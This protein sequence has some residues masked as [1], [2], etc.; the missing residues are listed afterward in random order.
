MT[1]RL[2]VNKKH[3]VSLWR[4]WAIFVILIFLKPE[5][6]ED[7]D[8]LDFLFNA[9]RFSL[10]IYY[11]FKLL[12]IRRN[13]N[14]QWLILVGIGAIVLFSTVVNG[15]LYSKALTHFFPSIGFIAFVSV[16]KK[17][18]KDI[19]AI[20][21]NMGIIL[22]VLNLVTVLLFPDGLLF[23]VADSLKIW[24][25]GQKQ[26]LGGFI[27]PFI[28]ATLVQSYYEESK[29]KNQIIVF[30]LSCITLTLEKSL[31]AIICVAVFAFLVIF[32]KYLLKVR[33]SMLVA[34]IAGAF[35]I[36]QYISFNFEEMVWLQNILSDIGQDGISKART[37]RV[38]FDMWKFA[39]DTIKSHLL[40]GVGNL[41]QDSWY[42]MSGLGYHSMLDNMYMDVLLTGGLSAFALFVGLIV[43]CFNTLKIYWAN[44]K[45]RQIGYSLFVLCILLLEGCPYFPSVFF[46]LSIP[47]WFKNKEREKNVV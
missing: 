31:G 32:D 25:L 16:N 13:P 21:A 30:M 4:L 8:V 7:I 23:R 14:R 45:I 17:R 42:R 20:I 15:G 34:A 12:F 6:V 39:W 41:T 28:F 2:S 38:R 46:M 47:I 26:D 11:S 40:F 27:L 1:D 44:R 3:T 10:A 24:I 29:G 18:I 43:N 36:V 19:I 37:V 33:K 9:G 5:I 22:L 35:L